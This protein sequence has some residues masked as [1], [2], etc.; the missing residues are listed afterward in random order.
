MSSLILVL[1]VA[2]DN[3]FTRVADGPPGLSVQRSV[4]GCCLLW[5]P[6]ALGSSVLLPVLRAQWMQAC[7]QASHPCPAGQPGTSAVS[8]PSWALVP[9]SPHSCHPKSELLG[10][11]SSAAVR[12]EQ[13]SFPQRVAGLSLSA[14]AICLTELLSFSDIRCACCHFLDVLLPGTVTFS[15]C[16]PL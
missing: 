4:P 3:V 16:E 5:V 9:V 14:V 12:L 6:A 8:W 13:K 10:Q 11:F 1:Q 7:V 2:S 15:V